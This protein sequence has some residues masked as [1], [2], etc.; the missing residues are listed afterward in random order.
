MADDDDYWEFLRSRLPRSI[1]EKMLADKV[2]SIDHGRTAVGNVRPCVHVSMRPVNCVQKRASVDAL[3]PLSGD[4]N[5]LFYSLHLKV[6]R[7]PPTV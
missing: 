5:F 2:R 3:Y 6:S 1:V 7:P 4:I